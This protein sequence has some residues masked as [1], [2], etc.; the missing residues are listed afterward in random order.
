MPGGAAARARCAATRAHGQRGRRPGRRRP[1]RLLV[2]LDA[3]GI[4]REVAADR[5]PH[6]GAPDRPRPR[7]ASS[8]TAASCHGPAGLRRLRGAGPR[9]RRGL[10]VDGPAAGLRR[11]G[12]ARCPRRPASR[13]RCGPPTGRPSGSPAGDVRPARP[14]HLPA[15]AR[16]RRPPARSGAP[17][18]TSRPP[19]PTAC[20][21]TGAPVDAWPSFSY[22]DEQYVRAVD[23]T[24]ALAAGRP[25][26]VGVLHRWYGPGQGRP[27]SR[28][29]PALPAVAV[30]RR[31]APRRASAP[32]RA[33]AST[34]PSGCPRRSATPTAATSSS[35]S[36]GGPIPRAGRA[37]ATTTARG[38]RPRSSGR[39]APRPSP[40]PTPQRTGDRG[41]ARPARAACTPCPAAPSW[42]TSAPSTPP[43]HGWSSPRDSPGR[44]VS[45]RA[46]Y[47]LDPGRAGLHAARHP[48]DEPLVLLHHGPGPRR[49]SRPS[50]TSGSATCRSTTRAS[51]SAGTRSSPSPGTPPCPACPWRRSPRTAGCSNAVWRLNGPLVPLLQPGAVRRHAD[52]G[53]GPVPLGRRQRVRGG[54]AGL[55]RPEPELA[56]PARRG[57]GPGPLLAR[58]AGQRRLPQRRRGAHLRDL[59]GALPRVALALLRRRPATAPP[60]C[61]STPRRRRRRTGCWSARQGG[62]GLL[63]G[64][65]D[66]S[67][68]DPVYGYDLI[69]AA[70]TASNVA[71]GQCLQPGGPAGRPGG[72][73]G[74]GGDPAG[75]V[76]PAGGSGQRR[77]AAP[78]RDLRRR[79]RRRR[80]PERAR[81]AGG[82]RTGPGLRRRAGRPRW[83]R[84]APTWPA[85]ASTSA[86]TT[87]SS[88]SAPWPRRA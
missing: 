26:A 20:S 17:R 77:A 64:L 82:Q 66:T 23:L 28:S 37:P 29:G 75:P 25:S 2:R 49:P 22:P 14:G 51:A 79:R 84:W 3:A 31:R 1:R 78:R 61:A 27:A 52:A 57:P 12:G 13:R 8:G 21:S 71:R 24:G 48:G 85:S 56:G 47:L 43:G 4:G 63:Y 62:T 18:P 54:H 5:L 70:D 58:R 55:R 86:P 41:V 83:P 15:H 16:S 88:S 40:A 65:A 45:M 68:G 6:R 59:H 19:T 73:R 36:T 81:L 76:G 72:G 32:T 46:G 7:R 87:A 44:T 67:N 34:R 9:R 53:E 10:R 60:R 33:G 30:V 74:A 69:V 11:A 39:P 38:R 42:P 50:P 35:G 80:R